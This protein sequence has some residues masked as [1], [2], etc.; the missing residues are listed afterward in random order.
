[1]AKAMLN[2]VSSGAISYDDF[3]EVIGF[4][5]QNEDG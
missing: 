4:R 2:E 5:I 3:A 1:M